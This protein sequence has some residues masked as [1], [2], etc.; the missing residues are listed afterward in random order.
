MN[1]IEYKTKQRKMILEYIEKNKDKQLTAYDILQNLYL[2]DENPSIATI[3]RY[4]EKLV[5]QGILKK[6]YS[7]K[8][9]A[10]TFEYVNKACANHYHLKCEKCGR[11]IHLSNEVFSDLESKIDKKYDFE[12]DNVK[13]VLYGICNECKN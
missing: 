2:K 13:T 10:A 5:K 3:Y 4:L 9:N 7:E 11:I 12:I 8:K 6:N 1:N